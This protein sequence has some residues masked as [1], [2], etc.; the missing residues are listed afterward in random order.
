MKKLSFL[1][2][3]VMLPLAV[4]AQKPLKVKVD[5]M[6]FELNTLTK[7]AELERNMSNPYRGHFIV[8]GK[9]TYEGQ[10]YVVLVSE[11]ARSI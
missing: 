8:P 11:R 2:L 3:I 5:G 9:I 10:E 1:L 6:K 4:C 7:E